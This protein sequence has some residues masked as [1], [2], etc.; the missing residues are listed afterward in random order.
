MQVSYLSRNDDVLHFFP[1][2]AG[3]GIPDL[4]MS[5]N[6]YAGLLVTVPQLE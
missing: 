4:A 2:N 5:C 6:A 1:M 3:F